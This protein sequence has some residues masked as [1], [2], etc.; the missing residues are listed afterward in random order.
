MQCLMEVRKWGIG[1]KWCVVGG[2][3]DDDKKTDNSQPGDFCIQTAIT[4]NIWKITYSKQL[5][6]SYSLCRYASSH[7]A[8][9]F[10][11][12]SLVVVRNVLP[13]R[14]RQQS[15]PKRQYIPVFIIDVVKAWRRNFSTQWRIV[16]RSCTSSCNQK[17]KPRFGNIPSMEILC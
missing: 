17:W 11:C 12:N 3:D 9:I 1:K 15:P 5:Y 4:A 7:F 2:D 16:S 6:C 8:T 13:R 14:E 10:S